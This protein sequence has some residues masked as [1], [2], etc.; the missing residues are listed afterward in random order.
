MNFTKPFINEAWERLGFNEPM[1]V[2]AEAFPLLLDG[3]DVTIEAPT[4]TGK[5]L[6]YLLPAIEKIDPT[7]E[8]IQ[9]VI[10]APTREL[11]MQIQNVAQRFTEKGD[12][13]IASFIGGVELKRQ[14][15]RL[16]K[17]PH[18]I[19]GTPG[20]LV[21]LIEK[22]KLK[23]HETH[24]VILDEADQIIDS[25]LTETAERII[26]HTAANRQIALVSATLT[27]SLNAWAAPFLNEP[28]HIKIE[29]AVN[30]Q[31]TFGYMLTTRRYKPELLRRLSHVDGVKALA[32]INN[33]SFLPPLKGELE[34]MN[35]NYRMLDSLKGKRERVETLREFRKGE[36]P[37]LI[38]TGLAARG[39]DIEEVTHVV[40]FDLPESIDD[41]IHRSG[42]TAR[43]NAAGT[44]LSLVTDEDLKHLKA[45]A[46]QLGVELKELEIYRGDVIE[47]RIEDKPKVIKRPANKR[48][49]RR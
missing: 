41:F 5:T 39:L 33:R 13:R 20:R 6:A 11:V 12:V 26:K 9:V 24:T 49:P 34:K 22:K 45:F 43:G 10:V 18:L 16:K 14:I 21:E 46:R 7:N 15:D 32:F 4:G 31:V 8:R 19:V 28:A 27:D 3:K 38:T 47:K 23:L 29:R 37:L 17:K 36:Y 48:G 1:P 2:Q 42:R 44:V 25:G 30:N 40:H 35:V